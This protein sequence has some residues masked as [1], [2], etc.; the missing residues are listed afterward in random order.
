MLTMMHVWIERGRWDEMR[1]KRDRDGSYHVLL[2]IVII[3]STTDCGAVGKCVKS[4][5]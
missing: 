5:L 1:M 2:V 3:G 4:W